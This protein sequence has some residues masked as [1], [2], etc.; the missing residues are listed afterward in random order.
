MDEHFRM[1]TMIKIARLYYEEE[2]NQAMIAKQLQLSKPMVSRLLSEARHRKLVEIII[3]YPW[4]NNAVLEAELVQKFHLKEA[5][6]L[7]VGE[8]AKDEIM[9]GVGVM[10]AQLL[11]NHLKNNMTL[12]ISRGTGAYAVVQELQP[13]P[14]LNINTIQLQGALGDRLGDGSDVAHFISSRYSGEFHFIHAPLVL[15]SRQAANALFQQPGIC[16]TLELC[17]KVDIALV[18]VGSI[19]PQ[20]SSLYRHGVLTQEELE[21]LAAQGI[22]GDIAGRHFDGNGIVLDIDFNY[23]LVCIRL[24]DL[25]K[26]PTIIGVASGIR[27]VPAMRAVLK[28]NL[29]NMLATD[30]TAAQLLLQG[31]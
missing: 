6:V 27:K 16:E 5:R 3:H 17:A 31:A 20:V 9:R 25:L 30:S 26:I 1:E 2:M 24:E 28:G 7:E 14:Y 13:Q 29:I 22:V 21:A 12:G 19:D 15:E 8:L 4:R 10:G 18:G 11:E 23:R